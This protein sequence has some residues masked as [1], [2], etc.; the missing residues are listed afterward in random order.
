MVAGGG[1]PPGRPLQRASLSRDGLDGSV[2]VDSEADP[3]ADPYAKQD[4]PRIHAHEE[5]APDRPVERR[6]DL[7]TDA[8]ADVGTEQ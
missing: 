7:M 8:A 4:E 2:S 1:L 6:P 3:G 5:P